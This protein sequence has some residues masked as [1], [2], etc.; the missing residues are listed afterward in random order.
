MAESLRVSRLIWC[1]R[2]SI[3][4]KRRLG[5]NRPPPRSRPRMNAPNS[6][7]PASVAGGPVPKLPVFDHERLDVYQLELQFVGW[8]T[9]LIEEAKQTAAGK[10][11]EVCD[12]LDRASLSALQH[13]RRQWQTA[14]SGPSEVF[15]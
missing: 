2:L 4:K 13:G 10:T 12:Q 7:S 6:S 1:K 8:V 3:S 11:R 9:P 15:R 5:S 14:A